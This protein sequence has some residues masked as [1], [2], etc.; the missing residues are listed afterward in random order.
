[1]KGTRK[2]LPP[3]TQQ[4]QPN[5]YHSLDLRSKKKIKIIKINNDFRAAAALE[6]AKATSSSTT[7]VDERR[8]LEII[9]RMHRV[10]MIL[11]LLVDQAHISRKINFKCYYFNDLLIQVHILETMSPM[12]FMDFRSY[13]SPASG[14]QSLQFRLLENKIGVKTVKKQNLIF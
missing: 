14:F 7:F 2:L 12:D 10:V 1:M 6:A 4:Q 9:K 8:M 3:P 5:N 13:L 11:K